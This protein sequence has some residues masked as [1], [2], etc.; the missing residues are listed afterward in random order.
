MASALS[1]VTSQ[2]LQMVHAAL[3]KES[4]PRRVLDF[5][6][7]APARAKALF[8]NQDAGRTFD[9]AA[10]YFEDMDG[11]AFLDELARQMGEPL[12]A[13]GH[14]WRFETTSLSRWGGIRTMDWLKAQ[15]LTPEQSR[16]LVVIDARLLDTRF[17]QLFSSARESVLRLQN[18]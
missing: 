10:V 16:G 15:G 5:E 4:Q 12:K 11:Y 13:P 17:E 2:D 14:E 1:P 7:S 8:Q 18:G 6:N 9:R 3:S